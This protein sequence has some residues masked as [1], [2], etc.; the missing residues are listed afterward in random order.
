[1]IVGATLTQGLATAAVRANKR[2]LGKLLELLGVLLEDQALSVRLEVLEQLPLLGVPE[3]AA[4]APA[5]AWPHPGRLHTACRM[6]TATAT[7]C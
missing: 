7:R 2:E 5:A 4:A 6:P 1:V 3:P